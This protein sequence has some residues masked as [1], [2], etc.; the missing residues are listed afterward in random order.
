ME[1]QSLV[2]IGKLT[3]LTDLKKKSLLNLSAAVFPVPPACTRGL[4][5]LQWGLLG[6]MLHVHPY[7][8]HDVR[9]D[10]SQTVYIVLV[11]LCYGRSQLDPFAERS[12][13]VYTAVHAAPCGVHALKQLCFVR[14]CTRANK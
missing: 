3:C 2:V 11:H 6:Q 10:V 1:I 4:I 5:A 14:D 7:G 13:A 8:M 12:L 9:I